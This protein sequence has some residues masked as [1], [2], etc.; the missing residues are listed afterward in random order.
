MFHMLPIPPVPSWEGLHPLVVH[1]PIGIL[2]GAPVFLLLAAILPVRARWCSLAALLSL[3][4][5]TSGLFVAV[6]T[7]R[8][9]RDEVE[10]GTD[11][12]FSVLDRHAELAGKTRNAFALLTASFATFV[13]ATHATKRLSQP[14]LLGAANA[15]FL[16]LLLGANLLLANAAHMGGRLVHEFAI[17]STLSPPV[18]SDRTGTLRDDDRVGRHLLQGRSAHCGIGRFSCVPVVGIASYRPAHDRGV[19]P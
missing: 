13:A 18:A 12:M 3:V 5:G 1:L 7:G 15:L 19:Q 16:L 4:M 10:E 11:E 6:A 14:V 2:L 17:R 9:A 8:A